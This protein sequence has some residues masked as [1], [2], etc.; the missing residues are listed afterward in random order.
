MAEAL[1]GSELRRPPF[2][3]RIDNRQRRVIIVDGSMI[4]VSEYRFV[5]TIAGSDTQL[6]LLVTAERR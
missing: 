2:G 6:D 4:T 5:P 1:P 3:M